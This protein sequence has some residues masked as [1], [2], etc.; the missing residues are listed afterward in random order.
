MDNNQ[1][2]TAKSYD[3][4]KALEEA[5]RRLSSIGTPNSPVGQI[6]QAQAQANIRETVNRLQ[7]LSK[8]GPP[9]SGDML[10]NMESY[11]R[12]Q[13]HVMGNGMTKQSYFGG[14][15]T[16]PGLA[17][18]GMAPYTDPLNSPARWGIP[19]WMND[20]REDEKLEVLAKAREWSSWY[21]MNHAVVPTC[22]NIYAKYPF[23]GLDMQCPDL[24]LRG[25]TKR[26][27]S[28]S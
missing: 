23:V 17:Q 26:F 1:V 4:R 6:R 20:M 21:Y 18:G 5:Q 3:V 14:G 11:Y 22:M 13:D 2:P 28:T 9:L 16:F 24:R 10:N 12:H 8:S 19:T 15:A 25:N 7:K 27:F